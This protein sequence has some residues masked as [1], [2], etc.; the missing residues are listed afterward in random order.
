MG[1]SLSTGNMATSSLVV[2]A[3]EMSKTEGHAQFL[4]GKLINPDSF[5]FH[6]QV[7]YLP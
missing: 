5:L 7:L 3:L 6:S 2:A 4:S 1:F